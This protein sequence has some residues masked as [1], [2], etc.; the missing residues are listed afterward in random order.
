MSLFAAMLFVVVT[1]FGLS[2]CNQQNQPDQPSQEPTVVGNWELES[3][4]EV[5]KTETGNLYN[6]YK[7][8][9]WYFN[10]SS[11]KSFVFYQGGDLIK[12]TY[13]VMGSNLICE[14]ENIT[15]K[16][17]IAEL[18]AGSL[19]LKEDFP[20]GWVEYKYKRSK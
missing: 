11:D 14:Y 20:E 15:M 1:T 19:V 13:S 16:Y 4:S 17:A 5:T 3:I 9:G 10:F 18:T 2:S 7:V 8:D 6:T 12:G